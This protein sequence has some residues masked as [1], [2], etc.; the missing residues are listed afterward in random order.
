MTN[1]ELGWLL[2]SGLTA[3]VITRASVKRIVQRTI[4]LRVAVEVL[5]FDLRLIC[6][7][8][9]RHSLRQ[10]LFDA[11]LARDRN[12]VVAFERLG[13]PLQLIHN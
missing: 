10:A 6:R 5:Q 8:G 13:D 1:M 9:L 4:G 3:C 11:L 2:V 7:L 12:L